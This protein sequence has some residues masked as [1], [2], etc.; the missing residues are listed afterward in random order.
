MFVWS[1]LCLGSGVDGCRPLRSCEDFPTGSPASDF[2][3][4]SDVAIFVHSPLFCS[5]CAIFGWKLGLGDRSDFLPYRP[6]KGR[7][8]PRDCSDRHHFELA[9]DDQ[10]SIARAEPDLAF[11][12]D[13]AGGAGYSR[14]PRFAAAADSRG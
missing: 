6:Q 9:R 7:H 11:P 4:Q 12:G 10:L 8:F 5:C 2:E 13:L 3:Q 14:L 1:C